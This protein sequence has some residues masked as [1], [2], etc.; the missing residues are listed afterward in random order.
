MGANTKIQW[1]DFTFNCW[2]GCTKVSAGCTN[3]YAETQS[4]RNPKV[5]GVWG[6]N[7]ARVVAS[8][9]YW[10]QPLK[11]EREAA[12]QLESWKRAVQE[13]R[14]EYDCVEPYE[15]PR[16]FCASLADVFEDRPELVA[17]RERLWALIASTPHLDWLLLTKRP[18]VALENWPLFAGYWASA[19]GDEATVSRVAQ[20]YVIPNVWLGVSVED[21]AAADTRIPLLLQ[22]PAK[23]R[24]LSVE[25]M[26]GPVD[27]TRLR[28]PG[29]Y[30]LNALTGERRDPV[31]DNFVAGPRVDWVIIG[32]ES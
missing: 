17:P 5:L 27:L 14:S 9:S 13:S 16:V 26:L 32:G 20:S 12:Q 30:V 6:D 29:G 19:C 25:P 22:T 23:V 7:G 21:Q 3:C 31:G 15:R 28:L 1:C 18:E 11:W 2:R 10:R 8:E 4:K 24:F